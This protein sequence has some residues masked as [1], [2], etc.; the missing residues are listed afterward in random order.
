M[1]QELIEKGRYRWIS[2]KDYLTHRFHRP[3]YKIPIHAGMTCPNIDGRV[4]KGGCTYCNN[5]SFSPTLREDATK[6]I[7][8]QMEDGM[9]YF[10]ERY[11]AE[12][13]IAYFQTY[14]N[15]YAP[16]DVLRDLWQTALSFDDIAGLAVGTRPDCVPDEVLD[17]LNEFTDGREVWLEFGLETANDELHEEMN[18]GHDIEHYVDAVDRASEYPFRI[19]THTILGLPG[20]TEEMMMKTHRLVAA[21]PV[22]EI[23]IHHY[24]VAPNTEL[25]EQFQEGAYDVLS[26]P[27]YRDLVCD[28]LEIL[29]P[30]MVVQ[31]LV[32]ELNPDWSLAPRWDKS[33]QEILADI[34]DELESRGTRQGSSYTGE[35]HF[36]TDVRH[37]IQNNRPEQIAVTEWT[38]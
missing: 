38:N 12:Q 29:P 35:S 10:R 15:T 31:R 27:A 2:I 33:K 11:D 5:Q 16:V 14:S 23:K 3:T 30:G 28:V 22:D 4:A 1:T 32:G 7:E 26:F 34:N 20:D 6:S 17:L 13:F 37:R 36:L 8:Q 21:A 25:A 9:S 24:Y 19:V 18:R